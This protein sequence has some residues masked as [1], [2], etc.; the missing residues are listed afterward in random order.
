M[1]CRLQYRRPRNATLVAAAIDLAAVVLT[2][3]DG[4]WRAVTA[5]RPAQRSGTPECHLFDVVAD[6]PPDAA[7]AVLQA[8]AELRVAALRSAVPVFERTTRTLYE[9][10]YIDE[11]ELVGTDYRRGDLTDPSNH[12]VWGE[13][14]VAELMAIEPSPHDLAVHLWGAISALVKIAKVDERQRA[15]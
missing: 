15:Q 13:V 3:G 11:D 2:T 14:S 8:A 9:S 10:G 5:T 4:R 6:D 7:R 1:I 12:F